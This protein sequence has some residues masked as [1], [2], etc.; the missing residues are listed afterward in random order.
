MHTILR[1]LAIVVISASLPVFLFTYGWGL[2]LIHDQVGMFLFLVLLVPQF[3]VW[4][5]LGSLIDRLRGQGRM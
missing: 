2:K 3:I 5:G 4:L 1:A